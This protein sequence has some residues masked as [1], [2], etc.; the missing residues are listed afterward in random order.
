MQSSTSLASFYWLCS[1]PQLP[2][3][4]FPPKAKTTSGS[5]MD[6]F[7]NFEFIDYTTSGP[8]ERF[9]TQIEESLK[10]WGLVNNRLSVFN[11]STTAAAEG[12]PGETCHTSDHQDHHGDNK[13]QAYQLREMLSLDDATYSLSYH[14]N[15]AR[16]NAAA[17]AERID[18]EFLP[19]TLDGVRH[20]SLHRWTSL[21][22]LL[23]ISPVT[24][25]DI[26][27]SA[28]SSSSVTSAIIDLS[29]AKLLLSSF[30]IAFQNT[31]CNIPVFVPTGQ[32][33]NLTFMGLMIQPQITTPVPSSVMSGAGFDDVMTEDGEDNCGVEVRFNTTLIPYPPSQ[34]TQLSGLLDYFVDRMGIEENDLTLP[35]GDHSQSTKERIYASAL[36]SYDLVNWYDEDWRRWRQDTDGEASNR[37]KLD[38]DVESTFQADESLS[39]ATSDGNMNLDDI[40]TESRAISILP[41]P[42][43]P[44]GPVQDPLHSLR[45]LARFASVPSN[46]YLDRVN[47]IDMDAYHANILILQA[48]FREDDYGILSGM[49]EDSIT[50]WNSEALVKGS[51]GKPEKD[52]SYT[53]LL[54]RGAKFI[55]GTI[56][57][58]DVVDVENIVDALFEPTQISTSAPEPPFLPSA[59]YDR[60]N[61]KLRPISASE[62]GLHFRHATTVPYNSF[63]WRMIQY[64]LD[65]ISPNSEIS[66]ATSVMGFMKVLWSELLKQFYSRWE[67]SQL[68]P[69]VDIFGE[70]NNYNTQKSTDKS[71]PDQEKKPVAI[72]LR[73]NLLH[74]KLAMLNC[75]ISRQIQR[76]KDAHGFVHPMMRRRRNKP[77]KIEEESLTLANIPQ[78][79]EPVYSGRTAQLQNL[80][81]GLS[82]IQRPRSSDV[83][84]IAKRFLETVK[85]RT[86]PQQ[87]ASPSS[88]SSSVTSEFSTFQSEL[89]VGSPS[90]TLAVPIPRGDLSRR[91]HSSSIH[92]QETIM[93]SDDDE[94][95]DIFYDSAETSE[96][97]SDPREMLRKAH[98]MSESFVALKYASSVDSQSG[99]L[100]DDFDQSTS[101]NANGPDPREVADETK[102]E[103]GLMPL[104]DLK[105]LRTGAPLLVP[106]LQEPGYMTEDMIQQQEELFETLGSSSDGAK[107]RAKMQSTQLT[108]D[109]EAF[110][111]ANP[112]CVLGD[113]IRWHS[114]KDWVEDKGEISAR[115]AD[116][117][118]YWQELWARSKRI[119]ISR[120]TPLFNH[121]QEAAKVLFYLD[122]IS[123]DQLFIHLF[124]QPISAYIRQV[125][126]GLKD[127]GHCLT[128]FPWHEISG[129]GG[130]N[131]N[132]NIILGKLRELELLMGRAIALVRKFPGQY[133]LVER[134]LDNN[135][136]VV[137]DGSERECVYDLFSV[138]GPSQS[139]PQ[140]TSREFI[141]KTFDPVPTAK[142]VTESDG[143]NSR[144]LQ[145]RMYACLKESEL[146]IVEAVAKD[147]LYM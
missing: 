70:T 82:D 56:T 111:A 67:N 141:L 66:Y 105:L 147:G 49:M 8:W 98:S 34:Y 27:A 77:N 53:S 107:M 118:N 133:D 137:E 12:Q 11:P 121:S 101:V 35:P 142:V 79:P 21:T 14:Y 115:M 39:V 58:V 129:D 37:E 54:N 126:L 97:I 123:A 104:K 120:Q 65:V 145:R 19:K 102:S 46:I 100:I 22:H 73:Y 108:S 13:S 2:N 48:I 16:S 30:A 131:A 15:P 45:L 134:I 106:K 90:T 6:D 28:V 10:S 75:C 122:S 7:E 23:I 41:I 112:G 80:L 109:M 5:S 113:F 119:P 31:G 59:V 78:G 84:P 4:H 1:I 42:V 146:R 117:G 138:G 116:A 3:A 139:F 94:G 83:I 99:V 110:K 25:P 85:N 29:S 68:I 81:H 9:I 20:H 89:E 125:A 32:P 26:F 57:M 60:L 88:V 86:I 40:K 51:D 95:E 144:P 127:L 93:D 91:R 96:I 64:L 143:L 18:L 43:L 132:L 52:Q 36:F 135:E 63:L 92:A 44:F 76:N 72:D 33:W 87:G 130:G 50:S 17:G 47:P 128:M 55:Q 74:Q 24:I 103:G 38:E 114:P 62:L 69:F 136:T 61:D 71:S 140:P 124:S